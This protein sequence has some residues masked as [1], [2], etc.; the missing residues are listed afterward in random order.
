V[1]FDHQSLIRKLT[2]LQSEIKMARESNDSLAKERL[3]ALLDGM[4]FLLNDAVDPDRDMEDLTEA[5]G[6]LKS[7]L[8]WDH[9]K[10]K[11]IDES[12][13]EDI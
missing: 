13:L 6:N 1:A 11:T 4:M 9:G 7:Q 3:S 2:K 10:A 5:V 12:T 8:F